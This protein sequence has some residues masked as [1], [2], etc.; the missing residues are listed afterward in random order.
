[1]LEKFQA[2]LQTLNQKATASGQAELLAVQSADIPP[3]AA[4]APRDYRATQVCLLPLAGKPKRLQVGQGGEPAQIL[5]MVDASRLVL[6]WLPCRQPS[7][8]V[9]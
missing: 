5:V 4:V 9:R 7:P 3:Q 6:Q 1:M 8:A 2:G